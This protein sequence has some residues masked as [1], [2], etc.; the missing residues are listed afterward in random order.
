[1]SFNE[2]AGA[3]PYKR[4]TKRRFY[5]W[6]GKKIGPILVKNDRYVRG[7]KGE[8]WHVRTFINGDIEYTRLDHY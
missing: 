4:H 1:M 5:R 7:P 3:Y 8:T 2:I 6:A